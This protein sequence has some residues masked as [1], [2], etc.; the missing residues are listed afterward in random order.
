MKKRLLVPFTHGIDTYALEYAVQFAKNYDAELVAAALLPSRAFIKDLR[1]EHIQQSRDFHETMRNKAQQHDVTVEIVEISAAHTVQH[2]HML[3]QE[4][5]CAGIVLFVRAGQGV[6]L[7][8][9]E[10]KDIM[11]ASP[12]KLYI[13]RLPASA[14]KRAFQ[15]LVQDFLHRLGIPGLVHS[16][17]SNLI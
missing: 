1:L 8:T 16:T 15:F 3:V 9:H 12:C 17:L 4:Q 14:G 2:I 6:L 10:I 7:D 13:L 11:A 5:E